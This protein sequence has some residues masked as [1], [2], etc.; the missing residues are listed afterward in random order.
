MP[1][2]WPEVW[3]SS[4]TPTPSF[5]PARPR[6]RR[7]C[8]AA[9]ELSVPVSV[10]VGP[11]ASNSVEITRL[12]GYAVHRRPAAASARPQAQR[13]AQLG[14]PPPPLVAV[15][16]TPDP[17]HNVRSRG[18]TGPAP[19]TTSCCRR[20]PRCQLPLINDIRFIQT[21]R[22]PKTRSKVR[23]NGPR[24]LGN[25]CAQVQLATAPAALAAV[26]L[27]IEVMDMASP[28][29]RVELRDTRSVPGRF[30]ALAATSN[31]PE[32][33]SW[34]GVE[35]DLCGTLAVHAH[36][37]GLASQVSRAPR[38]DVDD[39]EHP[40]L[41]PADHRARAGM[42]STAR[43]APRRSGTLARPAPSRRCCRWHARRRSAA[44]AASCSR[45]AAEPAH[46]QV[47]VADRGG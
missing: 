31:D 17:A 18:R 3:R 5:Q 44:A 4:R 16:R 29:G 7:F 8:E 40:R 26:A 23:S 38:D 42:N 11:P 34:T 14:L 37:Q 13:A 28:P 24:A 10:T 2:H 6:P 15:P 21:E 27:T 19:G 43:S 12:T 20:P 22:S 41:R 46:A 1:C 47:G 30:S 39:A 32:A 25:D 35:L 36:R 33:N 45:Q 9:R